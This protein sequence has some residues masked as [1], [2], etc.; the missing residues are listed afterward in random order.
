M[1]NEQN[2]QKR[3]E[4]SQPDRLSIINIVDDMATAEDEGTN[5]AVDEEI[6]A[7]T[8]ETKT[9]KNTAAHTAK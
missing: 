8:A 9:I 3:S 2:S 6:S 1:L 7:D 5:E 4:T